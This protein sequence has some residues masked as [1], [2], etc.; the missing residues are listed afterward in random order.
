MERSL[1]VN[2]PNHLFIAGLLVGSALTAFIFCFLVFNQIGK[3]SEFI[4]LSTK[5][6]IDA[7]HDI[8]EL[9]QACGDHCKDVNL[10]INK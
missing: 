4:E 9:K 5:M 1:T 2:K 3:N 8:A 10:T 7:Q 6:N